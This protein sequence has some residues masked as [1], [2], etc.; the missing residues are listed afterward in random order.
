MPWNRREDRPVPASLAQ[1]QERKII[2][3]LLHVLN[4]IVYNVML[5]GL[6]CL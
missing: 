4:V 3:V 2:K 6:V 1:D 5:V